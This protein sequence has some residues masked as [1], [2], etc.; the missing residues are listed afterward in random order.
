MTKV[1]HFYHFIFSNCFDGEAMGC[2]CA[3]QPDKNFFQMPPSI[4]PISVKKQMNWIVHLMVF[5][6]VINDL[7]TFTLQSSKLRRAL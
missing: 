1:Y 7:C 5:Y 4:Y 3:K 6:S 2:P